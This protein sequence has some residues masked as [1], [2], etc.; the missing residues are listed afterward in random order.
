MNNKKIKEYIFENN[1]D[2]E[3]IINDYAGY[4][5]TIIKNSGYSFNNEDIEEISSDVFLTIWK[6]K[7]KLDINKEI[8]PYICGICKNLILKKYRN[9]QNNIEDIDEF[10]NYL[11][12]KFDVTHIQIEDNEKIS[13]LTNQLMK[14]KEEDK[15]IFLYYYYK[16]KGINEISTTLGI[17][18]VKVKSRLSRIRRKLKKELEKRGYGYG[19]E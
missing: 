12:D 8:T 10:Q 17:S 3:K 6:N 2:I 19:K 14:M 7:E 9:I 1:L 13:I 18:T 11:Y 5:Y 15:N 16:S 4:V